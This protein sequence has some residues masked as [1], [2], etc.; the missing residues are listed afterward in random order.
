MNTQS[1]STATRPTISFAQWKSYNIIDVH[2]H[3]GSFR[4]YDLRTATLLDNLTRHAIRVALISNIDGAALPGTTQN[5]D[6]TTANNITLAT[7]RAY[8]GLLL[9]LAWAR[10]LD[11]NPQNLE[12]FL[13]DHGFVGVKLHP[14]MNHFPADDERV[15]KYLEL[16]ER[17]EVPAVF[18]CDRPGSNAS[19]ERI[20]AVA[21][22]H[23]SV[24][25]ILYHMSFGGEHEAA[26]NV[27]K[28][29]LQ[30]GDANL[31]LETAQADPA[32]AVRAVRELGSR[33][34]VFGSDATYYGAS[35]YENYIALVDA[36]HR[37]LSADDFAN[38]M[39]RNAE[40]LFKIAPAQK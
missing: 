13:R 32:A 38:V 37:E 27:V 9:G 8:P 20:Y 10:P 5:L 3:I 36:L 26:I 22:R 15:D 39:H 23:P 12:A 2:A 6:E 18:H 11:G 7:V 34:V 21:R 16:C 24:P 28:E 31:F 25:I 19:P 4:G 1:P 35:H 33:R 40:K 17:Y 29:A 14:E 30:K